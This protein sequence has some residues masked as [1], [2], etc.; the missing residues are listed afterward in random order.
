[1]DKPILGGTGEFF[2][3]HRTGALY[4][5]TTLVVPLKVNKDSG[6]SPCAFFYAKSAY[7]S[8]FNGVLNHR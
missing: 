5:G 8:C 2:G 7:Q 6:F 4:Q 3:C 1:M